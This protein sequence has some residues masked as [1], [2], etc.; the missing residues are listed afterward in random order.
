M[1][2]VLGPNGTG[3]S[4]LVA[5]IALGLGFPTSVLGRSNDIKEFIRHGQDKSF[6]ELVLKTGSDPQLRGE[7]FED[8]DSEF[9]SLAQ[10]V[11]SR[12]FIT[13]R[14]VI[15][16]LNGKAHNEWF[17]NDSPAN[18]RLIQQLARIL[19]AQVDNM[20]QFLP[21]DKVGDFVK[22][23][24]MQ[25][26]EATQ[27]AAAQPGT[28]QKHQRLIELRQ[29]D[30]EIE[31]GLERDRRQMREDE[32]QVNA[33]QE[34]KRAAQE[35]RDRV[36]RLRNL[37]QK[38]PWLKYKQLREDFV[39]KKEARNAAKERLERE[40]LELNADLQTQMASIEEQQKSLAKQKRAIDTQ[41]ARLR[42]S[43]E[44]EIG[45]QSQRSVQIENLK[46]A[47]LS[48]RSASARNRQQAERCRDELREMD[49]VIREKQ[50]ELEALNNNV[51]DPEGSDS[52]LKRISMK[53]REAQHER[54]QITAV[55]DA[56]KEEGTRHQTIIHEATLQLQKLDD[57]REQKRERLR[58]INI[59]AYRALQW[60]DSDGNRGKFR[61]PVIGPLCL[62]I[63]VKPNN[64]CP[65]M[66]RMVESC[67]SRQLLV[68]FVVT[69]RNDH[70]LFMRE[71]CDRGNL[72]INC[73]L[74]PELE[75]LKHTCPWKPED[76]KAFGFDG[77]LLDALQGSPSALQALCEVAFIHKI[78]FCLGAADERLDMRAC[79]QNPNLMKFVARDNFFELRRS[80]YAPNEVANRCSPLKQEMYLSSAR[81]A[82]GRQDLIARIDAARQ[83]QARLEREMHQK[84]NKSGNLDAEI[85][86]L[87]KQQSVLTEAKR[88]RTAIVA[89]LNAKREARDS[90]K[91]RLRELVRKAADFDESE[92]QAQVRD[93]LSEQAR[94]FAKIQQLQSEFNAVLMTAVDFSVKEQCLSL[95]QRHLAQILERNSSANEALRIA[96]QQAENAMIAAKAAAEEA[97]IE[98]QNS[99]TTIDEKIFSEV[100]MIGGYWS[101]LY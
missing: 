76:L 50:A 69:D 66:A 86:A 52:A 65:E 39:A 45:S 93:L 98:H 96:L 92:E 101:S 36:E 8:E 28:L 53:L 27:E 99:A 2:M 90:Q 56:L 30:R 44:R 68:S 85:E 70:E 94:C 97:L 67:I 78:P 55:R 47:I 88:A 16:N 19:R 75:R 91:R 100:I 31:A 81:D 1:N 14:R 71:C 5:A 24:P 49:E 42:A 73:I 62:E 61:A 25:M 11:Y 29:K 18:H 59:D 26:L 12:P 51:T 33:L 20:C 95:Q 15:S 58:S 22:M 79:E 10:G 89:M 80:R 60:L 72:R 13:I 38:R 4:T 77:V 57:H 54:D 63:A 32:A 3:K 41:R 87:R 6:I 17:L 83:Q 7:A 64:E 46:A 74:M 82:A 34:R 23:N 37:R 9:Y 21:Q 48:K 35:A 40:T 43:I 84:L